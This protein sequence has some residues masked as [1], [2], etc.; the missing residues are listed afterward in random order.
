MSKPARIGDLDIAQDIRSLNR[1]WKVQRAGWIVIALLLLA[2]LAG[3]FGSGPVGDAREE[4]AA[5][6]VDYVRDAVDVDA[7]SPPPLRVER[8]SERTVFVFAGSPGEARFSIRHRTA[9]R[10]D[11]TIGVDGGQAVAFSTFVYP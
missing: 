9:G 4:A 10:V 6:R 8:G 1:A 11:G 5:L 2:A 7:V 3:L